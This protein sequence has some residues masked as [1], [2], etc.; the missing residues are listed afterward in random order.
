MNDRFL[1][2]VLI[3]LSTFVRAAPGSVE[4]TID[5]VLWQA[6]DNEDGTC[7]IGG[8]HYS[9]AIDPSTE[10]AI[11]V[12]GTIFGARLVAIDNQAFSGCTKLTSITIPDSV[13]DIWNGVFAECSSLVSL[14]IPS[15]FAEDVAS[16]T[17][18][19]GCQVT[20]V[21]EAVFVNG[22]EIP[23]SWIEEHAV[24]ALA[25]AG[26]NREEALRST[27]GN[28]R[29]VWQCYVAGLEPEETEDLVVSIAMDGDRPDVSILAG[30]RT[31]R[32][33]E[34][35]GAPGPGGPWAVP[36]DDSFFFRMKVDLPAS[37]RTGSISFDSDG[38][39]PVGSITGLVGSAVIAPDP[40]TKTGYTFIGWSPALPALVPDGDVTIAARWRANRYIVRF[41]ANGGL[42]EM[43]DQVFEYGVPQALR[44]NEFRPSAH[45][46]RNFSFW[47]VDKDADPIWGGSRDFWNRQVVQDLA[48]EDGEIVTLWAIWTS[49][50]N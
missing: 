26:G 25:R 46:A 43:E 38:G 2:L 45:T 7:Y 10:G 16:W 12:P 40:P 9:P 49:E 30:G 24:E 1:C 47:S 44:A 8:H 33:Y 28:G 22:V 20:V 32:V 36:N 29:P 23:V 34:L 15:R 35:Q 5:G 18:P 3:G 37:F 14:Y 31:N 41:D 27:A 48:T 4:E 13:E 17:L 6:A 11:T 50:P 42:G 21:E 39:S 19:A